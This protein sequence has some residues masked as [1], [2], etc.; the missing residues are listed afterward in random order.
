MSP[1]VSLLESQLKVHSVEW[2]KR[3]QASLAMKLNSHQTFA[4]AGRDFPTTISADGVLEDAYYVTLQQLFGE[5]M[6]LVGP[7]HCHVKFSH[8]AFKMLSR[9]GALIYTSLCLPAK[10]FPLCMFSLVK[11]PGRGTTLASTRSCLLD[12]WSKG[13]INLYPTLSGQ[14]FQQVLEAHAHVSAVSIS[15]IEANYASLRRLLVGRNMTWSMELSDLSA[16]FV[17]Q[18]FRKTRMRDASADL[19]PGSGTNTRKRKAKVLQD[20]KV[21]PKRAP[22]VWN[23]YVK[24]VT[25]GSAGLPNLREV[26]RQY[27]CA[28]S[29]GDPML[30]T[31]RAMSS[32]AKVVAKKHATAR[33]SFG[34]TK[35]EKQRQRI[36]HVRENLFQRTKGCNLA[37]K[38]LA[39]ANMHS[40]TEL[41]TCLAIARRLVRLQRAD[42]VQEHLLEKQ[43][44]LA[45]QQG[46]GQ[47]QKD[48]SSWF[49]F[50][51]FLFGAHPFSSWSML[52]SSSKWCS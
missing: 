25:T 52:H 36:K 4:G 48:D 27:H 34:M 8:T 26:S 39:I 47:A 38:A 44:L 18:C 15:S 13:M 7:T 21:K 29:R 14:E 11:H 28:K 51:C 22:G 16:E 46:L 33:S 24:Y 20:D 10:Q 45:F 30:E 35:E 19:E 1:L 5:C 12:C 17:L 42:E 43:T 3:Q 41:D 49:A 6:E 31:C 2:E 37:Q 23:A 40:G 50:G 32:A 9:Q